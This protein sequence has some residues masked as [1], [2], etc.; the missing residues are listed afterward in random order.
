MFQQGVGQIAGPLIVGLFAGSSG[1]R[2]I[3]SL[4]A[5]LALVVSNVVL[6]V[7]DDEPSIATQ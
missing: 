7:V 2:V 5:V 3:P 6:Y 1:A 4:L